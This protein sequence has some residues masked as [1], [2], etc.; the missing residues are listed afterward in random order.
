MSEER[1]PF[2]A[3]EYN[4]RKFRENIEMVYTLMEL[5]NLLDDT[6]NLSTEEQ[7]GINAIIDLAIKN[8]S[9]HISKKGG[10]WN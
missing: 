6:K 1:T 4:I 9:E 8:L 3:A 10:K 2:E 5:K 7:E